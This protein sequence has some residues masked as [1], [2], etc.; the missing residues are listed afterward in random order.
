L[1]ATTGNTSNAQATGEIKAELNGL[2]KKLADLGVSGGGEV[3]SSEYKGLLQQDLPAALRDLRECK[4]NVFNVLQEKLIVITKQNDK[5]GDLE[6]RLKRLEPRTL[7]AEQQRVI[8]TFLQ[9][10]AGYSY[11]MVVGADGMCA[12]CYQYAIDFMGLLANA[13]WRRELIGVYAARGASPK[14][15]AILTPDISAPRPEAIALA[16]GLKEAGIPFDMN[17]GSELDPNGS[18]KGVAGVII[19]PKASAYTPSSK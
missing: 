7:S 6:A 15:V 5:S 10:P 14:G 3:T 13:S 4:L 12:D 11:V 19:T 9:V 18:A 2:I 17:Q 1:V 8:Q 16:K